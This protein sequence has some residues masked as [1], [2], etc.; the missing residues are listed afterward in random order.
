[1]NGTEISRAQAYER[2]MLKFN[3]EAI[4]IPLSALTAWLT[5]GR[6]RHA[7]NA[8]HAAIAL[9]AYLE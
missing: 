7:R 6:Y 3:S 9:P 5:I 8:L 1:M 4:L 2:R